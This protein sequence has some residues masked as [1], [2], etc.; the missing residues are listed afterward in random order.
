[1]CVGYC[2][3][4]FQLSGSSVKLR[5]ESW[6]HEFPARSGEV[7]LQALQL[8]SV[9]LYV[10]KK[11]FLELPSVIGCPD[12]ADGGAFWI[13][14]RFTHEQQHK[15]TF[16]YFHEPE[17]IKELVFTLKRISQQADKIVFPTE[18]TQLAH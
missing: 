18:L 15:V 6:N 13:E 17:S 4:E 16:E 9:S 12:C 8:D 14:I 1:M 5:Q 2:N 10:N 3:K 11:A 7:E